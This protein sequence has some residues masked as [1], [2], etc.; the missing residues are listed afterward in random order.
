MI[1][2]GYRPSETACAALDQFCLDA[3]IPHM[4]IKP[5]EGRAIKNKTSKRVIPLVGASLE[6]INAFP[7]GF[8][9]YRDSDHRGGPRF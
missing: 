2:T 8:P 7:D 9:T 5:R 1:N 6:A 4:I 3:E